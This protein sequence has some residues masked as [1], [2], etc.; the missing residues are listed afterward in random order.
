MLRYRNS[1]YDSFVA[2]SC[3]NPAGRCGVM[4]RPRR[5]QGPAAS[6]RTGVTT[7]RD[8]N[9]RKVRAVGSVLMGRR[10]CVRTALACICRTRCGFFRDHAGAN[11]RDRTCWSVDVLRRPGASD[12]GK[13]AIGRSRTTTPRIPE[14]M[15]HAGAGL[16]PA[17]KAFFAQMNSPC[18]A[19]SCCE[20]S[21]CRTPTRRDGRRFP[22]PGRLRYCAVDE[23][24]NGRSG[25]VWGDFIT[26]LEGRTRGLTAVAVVVGFPQPGAERRVRTWTLA[27]RGG[28]RLGRSNRN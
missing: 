26:E 3:G 16:A 15:D 7:S 25:P 8:W 5:I 12:H 2:H 23:N 18:N 20:T 21:T 28:S 22:D 1:L 10:G 27:F 14:N 9:G 19:M 24:P 6:V 13:P 11:G 17:W 4:G